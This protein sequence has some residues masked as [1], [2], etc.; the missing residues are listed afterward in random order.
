AV[1]RHRDARLSPLLHLPRSNPCRDLHQLGVRRHLL[2]RLPRAVAGQPGCRRLRRD[3]CRDLRLAGS[4]VADDDRPVGRG[5]HRR[6]GRAHPDRRRRHRPLPARGSAGVVPR[7]RPRSCRLPPAH[8]RTRPH[9][10]R[11]RAL[12]HRAPF[13]GLRGPRVRARPPA[14]RGRQLRHPVP[15][16]ELCVLAARP[17]GTEGHERRLRDLLQRDDAAAGAVPRPAGRHRPGPA[18]GGLRAGA[19]RHLARQAGRARPGCGPRVPGD[20]GRGPARLLSAGPERRDAQGGG[21]RWL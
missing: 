1:R 16:G 19:S 13:L 3:G 4:G 9:R 8:A 7:Q 20:V 14:G 10:D 18:L 21:P 11:R 6:P 2:L 15:G 5:Q 17:V 12:R